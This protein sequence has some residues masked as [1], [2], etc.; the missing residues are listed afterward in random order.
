[1][2]LVANALKALTQRPPMSATGLAGSFAAAGGI[3]GGFGGGGPVAQMQAYGTASWLMAVVDRLTSGVSQVE[4][5]LY[6]GRGGAEIERHPF[7]DFWDRPNPW[8]SGEELIETGQ[9]HYELT[10]ETWWVL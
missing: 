4:W 6:A 10:G 3:T 5:R 8:A 1:M 9:Q 2:T 7:L